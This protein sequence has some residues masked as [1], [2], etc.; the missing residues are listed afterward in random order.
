LT[1]LTLI[2]LLGLP[3]QVCW[4]FLEAMKPRCYIMIIMS[5]A[6]DE[7]TSNDVVNLVSD[8]DESDDTD[9]GKFPASR[10]TLPTPP[11][12]GCLPAAPRISAVTVDNKACAS[13]GSVDRAHSCK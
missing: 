5:A 4:Y 6:L 3:K 2:T 7:R 10:L 9:N 13:A 12:Y 1:T 8:D 11:H